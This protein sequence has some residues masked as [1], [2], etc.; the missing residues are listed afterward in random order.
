MFVSSLQNDYI[1]AGGPGNEQFAGSIASRMT[2]ATGAFQL[3]SPRQSLS[4]H[5]GQH[6]FFCWILVIK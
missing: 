4:L 2:S 5:L 1:A 6:A 3:Y